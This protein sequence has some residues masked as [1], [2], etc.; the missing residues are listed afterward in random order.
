M[1]SLDEN[2]QI[3]EIKKCKFQFSFFPKRSKED[4]LPK[5]SELLKEWN[6]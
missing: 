3:C 4:R 2:L 6:F 1:A 5:V